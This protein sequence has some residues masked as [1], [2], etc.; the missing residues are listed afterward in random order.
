V[1]LKLLEPDA[2]PPGQEDQAVIGTVLGI[3]ADTATEVMGTVL[4]TGIK[5]NI[6]QRQYEPNPPRPKRVHQL[7]SLLH[8]KRQ[9]EQIDCLC[10]LSSRWPLGD[11]SACLPLARR[12]EFSPPAQCRLDRE[13]VKRLADF[14]T[15]SLFLEATGEDLPL[16]AAAEK[17]P[18]LPRE[19]ALE[20]R[21]DVDF[22]IP[23]N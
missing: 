18:R 16:K 22:G 5:A 12:S 7:L 2:R 13:T 20:H 15:V 4:A 8:N 9:A 3:M 1:W 21:G 14:P 17:L 19:L 23:P 6:D 10:T 11:I